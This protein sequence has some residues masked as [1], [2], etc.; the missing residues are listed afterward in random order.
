MTGLVHS[1]LGHIDDA[2][3]TATT[4]P[5]GQNRESGE[6]GERH[7]NIH[8]NLNENEPRDGVDTRLNSIRRLLGYIG[9]SLN[10]LDR[11]PN[12]S[13]AA[14][15]IVGTGG[16]VNVGPT[17]A[18]A[19]S[20]TA[21]TGPNIGSAPQVTVQTGTVSGNGSLNSLLENIILNST[22]AIA[23]SFN[24]DGSVEI[25]SSGVPSTASST[26]SNTATA[27][28]APPD[29]S[30]SSSTPTSTTNTA[31]NQTPAG[32][33]NAR[34]ER[35]LFE[36]MRTSMEETQRTQERL[37]RHLVR[38]TNA[39][40]S[41]SQAS[42]EDL[43]TLQSDHRLISRAMHHI[44][45]VYHLLSDLQVNFV[46]RERN[47]IGLFTQTG[48][49][50]MSSSRNTRRSIPQMR[51]M[52]ET[53][54]PR[55]QAQRTSSTAA[56]PSGTIGSAAA[57]AS[58]TNLTNWDHAAS[59]PSTTAS[60]LGT[61][62]RGG[63]AGSLYLSQAPIV[64]MTRPNSNLSGAL[65][66]LTSTAQQAT[67]TTPNNLTTSSNIT[68]NISSGQNALNFQP[69]NISNVQ[70]QPN[71]VSNSP[72]NSQ[73]QPNVAPQ[74]PTNTQQHPTPISAQQPSQQQAPNG[75]RTAHASAPFSFV[76][77]ESAHTSP[78]S[79]GHILDPFWA[80][81]NSVFCHPEIREVF[82]ISL[83]AVPDF[84]FGA[85][86]PTQPARQSNQANLSSG[87]NSRPT[88]VNFIRDLYSIVL[89][90]IPQNELISL[91]I[92]RDFTPLNRVRDHLQHYVRD[93]MFEGQQPNLEQIDLRVRSM[94]ESLQTQVNHVFVSINTYIND[95]RSLTNIVMF[96]LL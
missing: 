7:L 8:I 23:R 38:M 50:R 33:A 72:T 73:Q 78:T 43:T 55:E 84:G 31:S 45:H 79:I 95:Y 28:L 37:N 19:A 30:A 87:P 14:N 93:V 58:T 44:A 59:N 67:R 9:A 91:L 6:A 96:C 41:A 68:T 65:N 2:M 85:A 51:S 22:S 36:L 34:P 92:S 52:S 49:P 35:N 27:Q 63:L 10:E 80:G 13:M 26:T 18:G 48:N 20:S 57:F 76:S 60:G 74:P 61:S 81:C 29:D 3:R 56:S 47:Q 1:L 16:N 64:V 75:S 88:D 54:R 12:S 32:Y 62:L 82:D 86:R 69:I 39:M 94:A 71:V 77:L 70:Q 66:L 46:Q 21:P 89:Q 17:N 15:V 4:N 90:H 24:I 83:I 53:R 25:Q 40:Q 11:I 5:A 42:Q